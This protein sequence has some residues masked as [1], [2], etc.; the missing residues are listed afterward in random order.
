MAEKRKYNSGMNAKGLENSVSEDQARHMATHQ[1][2]TY[3]FIVEAH[4]GPK[5]VGEDGSEKVSL[6][7]DLVELVPAEHEA[8]VRTFMRALYLTRPDQFGQA[9]FEEATPGERDVDAAAGGLDALV[10]KDDSGAPIG[11]WDGS[12]D[13]AECP[14]PDCNLAS[15]HDGD[16]QSE[17]KADDGGSV[18]EFSG[19][20]KAAAKA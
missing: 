9:A 14:A 6:I 16:H 13:T 1:G 2:H 10:E 3:V 17:N 4:S 12:E 11:I 19:K 7:P 15:G 5:V 18:V 8:R 20:G